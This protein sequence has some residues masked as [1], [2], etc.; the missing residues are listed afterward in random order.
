MET[1]TLHT[2]L[3][4]IHLFGLAL[5][6]GGAFTSDG[7]FFASLRDKKISKDEV[8]ILETTSKITWIGIGVLLFSGIG[9]FAMNPEF[10]S[11]STKFL[12]KMIIVLI[13]ILNG[14]IFKI[15]HMPFVKDNIGKILYR[16]GHLNKLKNT[17]PL[18]ISGVVSVTSWAS[19]I[20]LGAL[21]SV[22]YSYIGIL[23]LYFGILSLG[24]LT[25]YFLFKGFLDSKN[26]K[27]L[28]RCFISLFALT[29]VLLGLSLLTKSPNTESPQLV[30]ETTSVSQN[31]VDVPADSY[32]VDDVA[33]HNNSEDCWLI[34]D[35]LV[36]DVT[37]ASR[38][39]PAMFNCGTDASVNY[40]K[41]HGKG[42]RDKMMVLKIGTLN[43]L[44][45]VHNVDFVFE[46]AEQLDPKPE[47]YM[48]TGS[49]EN[50][51]LIIVVEKDAE[52][53]LFID[54]TTHENV[55]RIHDIGF[56]P[57][58][59]VFSPDAKFM[60]II[61]RDGWLTKIS[62]DDLSIIKT[63]SVGENSRG[64][65]LTEDGKYV[66][67]GNYEPG[68]VVVLDAASME[69]LKTI[70]LTGEKDGETVESRA[71]ALVENGQKIIVALKD[72]TSVWVIDTDKD[73]EVT[74]KFWGIGGEVPALH[75]GY[76]TPEGKHFIVSSQGSKT[77]WVLDT[78]TMEPIAEVETG[79]TPHTGPGATWGKTTY[80]PALG[81]GLITAIN[82]ETWE[83]E[84]SI[85][86]GGP[87][88]FIRS[89]PR[90]PSYP[91]IWADTAFGD[92]NDEIYVIDARV[93]EIVKTIRPVPGESSWHPEFT[94]DGNFVYI[95]SQTANEVEVYDAHTFEIV[96][97][98]EADTPSAVSN[99]GLRIEELGI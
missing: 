6:A 1:A 80:V 68:N 5:G 50:E 22:D 71:G 4:I 88:L 33:L 63:I 21:R 98:I 8:G 20:I 25:C 42:I 24:L 46:K 99:V 70:P 26:N 62:L 86:T 61:S 45:G 18:L 79:D 87:G 38:V 54:G 94:L 13:I 43:D 60:Y 2:I 29:V 78:E 73:F 92:N 81:E 40:H 34:V 56:Q 83:V 28:R 12:A 64:T 9:L 16:K 44:E 15:I 11:D 41:N 55:G 58:T 96:K 82:T 52:K 23:S 36:F 65:A 10:F 30:S 72:L 37:A 53:L 32:S 97:R 59:S 95:V 17:A 14:V 57:H 75:D 27:K 84:A 19:V 66:A 31:V 47:L 49:W 89:Y 39:H 91:Y 77:A 85:E 48:E 3:I 74:N 76:L 35:E 93:N 69:V 90:D 7:I 51:E 67:V